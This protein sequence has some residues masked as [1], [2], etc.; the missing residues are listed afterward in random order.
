MKTLLK[1]GTVINVFTGEAEQ[2]NVLIDDKIIIGIGDYSDSDADIIRD[3]AG[4]YICP[5]FIDGHIHIEST[6]LSPSEFAHAA[7]PHGTTSVVTDSHEIANVGGIAGIRYMLE[8][9]ENIPLTMYFVLPS[10]VPATHFDENGASLNAADLDSLYNHP[11]VLGLGEVMDYP[12]VIAQNPEIFKKIQGAKSRNLSVN[13]HAPLLAGRMLDRYISAG[14]EDDH[15]CSSAEEAKERIRKGQRVMIRQGTAARNLSA[16]LPLFDEPWAHRCLLVTDDKHPADLLNQGHIDEIIRQAVKAGKNPITAIRMATIQ[17]AEH[18]GLK[19]LGAVAPGYIADLLI[20]D[21]LDTVSVCDVYRNGI[22]VVEY[23]KMVPC[24]F[25]PVQQ[26][27]DYS[28]RHSFHMDKLSEADFRLD[29][30]RERKCRVIQLIKGE[31]L[32]NI[33]MELI[34][35]SKHNGIDVDRDI[36]KIAVVER[37][38]NTGHIGVGFISGIGLRSGAIASSVSHDS[39]NLIIIGTD[40]AEMAMAGNRIREIDGGLVVVREGSVLA[41]MSLPIAGLISDL[42][43]TTVSMQNEV[44]REAVHQL[45]SPSDIEPFM[46]MAFISLPV[47]P[48]IKI[49]TKGLIDV[50]NQKIVSLFADGNEEC[51]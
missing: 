30:D 35:F 24:W 38:H 39:H 10:C 42:P 48:H 19:Q 43:A 47:I 44:V 14:I 23:H 34:D 51:L 1:N 36:L 49:N 25:P 7:V 41:E 27:L 40:E 15:E 21:D 17:A 16:L 45:G 31:L 46:T 5:G 9:S 32:T 13:G 26:K 37:H 2:T 20:L 11:R 50:D 33:H 22:R 12:A 4:K 29:C 6:M 3:V 8:A 28:I 18:F